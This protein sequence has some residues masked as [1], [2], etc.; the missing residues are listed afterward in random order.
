MGKKIEM[1]KRVNAKTRADLRVKYDYKELEQHRKK[2]KYQ[3]NQARK[4]CKEAQEQ[5]TKRKHILESF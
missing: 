1:Q 2:Y 3:E 5:V 4:A